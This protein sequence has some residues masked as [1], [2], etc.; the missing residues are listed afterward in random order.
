[1]NSVFVFV[2]LFKP[3]LWKCGC[4]KWSNFETQP[5]IARNISDVTSPNN[6]VKKTVFILNLLSIFQVFIFEEKRSEKK[7]IFEDQGPFSTQDGAFNGWK[8]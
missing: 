7:F 4:Q 8:N 2:L 6:F 1:M 3:T 5:T